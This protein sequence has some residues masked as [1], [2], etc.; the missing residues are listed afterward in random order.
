MARKTP[1]KSKAEKAEDK[2]ILMSLAQIQDFQITAQ[3]VMVMKIIAKQESNGKPVDICGKIL[4]DWDEKQEDRISTVFGC[5][6][7]RLLC[8][9]FG[10][11]QKMKGRIVHVLSCE[12]KIIGFQTLRLESPGGKPSTILWDDILKKTTKEKE[13]AA[14]G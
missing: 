3:P 10:S 5:E 1:A 12:D 2:K 4:D 9:T 11:L 13:D 6:V 7:I 14:K 8:L